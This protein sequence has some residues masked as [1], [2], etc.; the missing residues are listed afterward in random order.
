M[1]SE[2]QPAPV[3][4]EGGSGKKK[5]YKMLITVNPAYCKGCGICAAFCPEEVF[6]MRGELAV[7]VRPENCRYCLDCEM[8]CPD[9]AVSVERIRLP[10]DG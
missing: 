7:V 5:R 10:E 3:E 9:F 8:R 4:P 6:E 2:E 1:A